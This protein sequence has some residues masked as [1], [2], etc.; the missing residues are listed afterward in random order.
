MISYSRQGVNQIDGIDFDKNVTNAAM[1]KHLG[2]I[3]LEYKTLM[4]KKGKLKEKGGAFKKRTEAPGAPAPKKAAKKQ[5]TPKSH[6]AESLPRRVPTIRM[7]AKQLIGS[8]AREAIPDNLIEDFPQNVEGYIPKSSS[9]QELVTLSTFRLV[10]EPIFKTG[11]GSSIS[12]QTEENRE[13]MRDLS[14]ILEEAI[15]AI[16][17]SSRASLPI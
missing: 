7:V 4:D 6:L 17:I 8:M 11:Q 13:S 9:V 14:P 12:R 16:R 2:Y 3:I 10:D 1:R 5:K 15:I